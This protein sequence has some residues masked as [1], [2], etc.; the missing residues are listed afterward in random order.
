MSGQ[1]DRWPPLPQ[2]QIRIHFLTLAGTL[3]TVSV[4]EAKHLVIRNAGQR[5]RDGPGDR[6]GGAG[7]MATTLWGSLSKMYQVR[8]KHSEGKC[9]Y[10]N[11]RRYEYVYTRAYT[12]THTHIGI[13]QKPKRRKVILGEGGTR[14]AG[15][16]RP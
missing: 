2:G 8:R 1:W 13:R 4:L 14:G 5:R 15:R 16:D 7:G 10:T 3:G 12:H 6:P 9:V 11:K